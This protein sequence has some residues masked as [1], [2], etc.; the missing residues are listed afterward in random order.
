MRS[1]LCS[2]AA[3]RSGS[4]RPAKSPVA[5]SETASCSSLKREVHQAPLPGRHEH[6]QRQLLV[7]VDELGPHRHADRD[8]LGLDAAEVGDHPRPLL[9]LDQADRQ[10]VLERGH[11]GVVHHDVGVQG[12]AAARVD[13]VPLE[14]AAVGAG[15]QRR[16]AQG[17]ARGAVLDQQLVGA[18]ALEPERVVLG[19][20]RLRAR[21]ARRL[22]VGR[23]VLEDAEA[24]GGDRLA[25]VEER[26]HLR[27]PAPATPARR[28]RARPRSPAGS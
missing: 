15:R 18:G 25:G 7:E 27:R 23:Q 5:A 9:Q 20:R 12:A 22:A 24:H 13:G 16:V 17:A 11:L 4:T 8:V 21:R 19:Q 10:R 28:R 26:L 3:I 6:G 14:R 1:S 2:T